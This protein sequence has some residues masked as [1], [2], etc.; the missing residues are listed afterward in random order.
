MMSPAAKGA[1][2][3]LAARVARMGQEANPAVAAAYGTGGK[4]RG[5]SQDRIE[6]GLML[7]NERISVVVLVPIFAKRIKFRDGYSKIT[8]FSVKMLIGFCI[9]SSYSFDAKASRGRARF[10]YAAKPKR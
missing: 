9:A 7:T 4:I 1:A 8:R 10:F 5:L 2:E 6:S 3:V